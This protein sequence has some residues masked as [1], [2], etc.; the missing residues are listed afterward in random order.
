MN[1]H[2]F[3]FYLAFQLLSHRSHGLIV[4]IYNQFRNL[5]DN[6]DFELATLDAPQ[7][8]NGVQLM[9]SM[10]LKA[11][12]PTAWIFWLPVSIQSVMSLPKYDVDNTHRDE[13]QVYYL[14]REILEWFCSTRFKGEDCRIDPASH[15]I[16][17]ETLA[18]HCLVTLCGWTVK[19]N[20]SLKS[21]SPVSQTFKW[22][23]LSNMTV[24]FRIW[25]KPVGVCRHC[26]S[27]LSSC[28]YWG[29]LKYVSFSF[30]HSNCVFTSL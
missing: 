4:G 30:F 14:H 2:K 3:S 25:K 8:R 1:V 23:R 11:T 19:S 13:S 26:A 5:S 15:L 6:F 10:Q 22:Q 7:R 24:W 18:S 27:Q 16:C 17:W 9:L 29:E 12:C 20:W 28:K 21:Y